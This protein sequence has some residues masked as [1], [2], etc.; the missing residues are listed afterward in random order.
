MTLVVDSSVAVKWVYLEEASDR[1]LTLLSETLLAPDLLLAECA[2]VFWKKVRRGEMSRDEALMAGVA[3][4]H[5]P[6]RLTATEALF[7][8][9]LALALELDHPAYDCL[10]LALARTNGCPMITADARLVGVLHRAQPSGI[11]VQLL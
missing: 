6:L 3:L 5:A 1:A 4:A 7:A 8:D 9:A 2:N 11:Q 10:Y